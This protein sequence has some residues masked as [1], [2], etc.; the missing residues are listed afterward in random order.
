MMRKLLFAG[1]A[2]VGLFGVVNLC[3]ADGPMPAPAPVVVPGPVPGVGCPCPCPEPCGEKV[4]RPILEK[5]T[6]VT[7]VYDDK[8]EDF[9]YPRCGF[10][11]LFGGCCGGCDGDCGPDHKCGHV[12][13]KKALIV[14]QRKCDEMVPKCVVE[15]VAPACPAPCAMP[16]APHQMMLPPGPQHPGVA[17]MQLPKQ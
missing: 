8:C 15:T 7:R 13:T 4:C 9:C 17:P 6:V 11:G 2:L 16:C 10:L 3:T 5:K 1:L 14:K 12:H